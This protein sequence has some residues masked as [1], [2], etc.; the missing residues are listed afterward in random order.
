MKTVNNNESKTTRDLVFMIDTTGSM[1]SAIQALRT[2]VPEAV[3]FTMLTGVFDRI[4][5]LQYKDYD[6]PEVVSHSA[7]QPAT[8]DG[9]NTLI[10]YAQSLQP[11]GGAGQPEAVKTA[12][13]QLADLLQ[14]PT[15]VMHITDAPMH[16]KRLDREG[17]KE[18][19]VL[20]KYFNSTTL[21][22]HL[23][24]N[25]PVR[26]YALTMHEERQYYYFAARMDGSV[27]A[28]GSFHT[29]KL[30]QSM[31][32][33]ILS[34]V[35]EQL[36]G[37]R[38]NSLSGDII[39]T[40]S[41]DNILVQRYNQAAVLVGKNTDHTNRVFDVLDRIVDT[42]VMMLVHSPLFGSIWRAVCA[43]RRDNRRAT[44]I[45]RLSNKI[46]TLPAADADEL[47][48]WIQNSYDR[49]A[50]I[51]EELEEFI[52]EHGLHGTLS[53]H[54]DMTISPKDLINSFSTLGRD[55]RAR[56]IHVLTRLR[57]DN[58]DQKTLESGQLP[59]NLP[60]NKLFSLLLHTVAPGTKASQRIAALIAM[61]AVMSQSVLKEQAL[62]YLGKI[63]GTWLC[64]D[65]DEDGKPVIGEN[66]NGN[67]AYVC[68]NVSKHHPELFTPEELENV[69][70]INVLCRAYRLK[71]CEVTVE[72]EMRGGMDRRFRGYRTECK[73][74]HN[75]YP[76]TLINDVG[77]CGY[78]EFDMDVRY[79]PENDNFQQY[80]CTT[81]GYF[82]SANPNIHISGRRQC[83]WCK[84][85]QE[86]LDYIAQHGMSDCPPDHK[87]PGYQCT[88]CGLKYA[89]HIHHD[90]CA[91]CVN[92]EA[93]PEMRFNQS[94][95]LTH[96]LLNPEQLHGV[97]LTQG[98][99][100]GMVPPR[101]YD[102]FRQV[103]F[104]DPVPHVPS[105]L[106]WQEQEVCNQDAVWGTI[107]D[108]MDGK[109]V[110]LPSCSICCDT[111]RP[112]QLVL[113]CGRKSCGQRVCF[114]CGADWY[115]SEVGQLYNPRH[116][117]CPF[118][119]RLPAP[120]CCARWGVRTAGR[121]LDSSYYYAVCCTC[122]T[123][124]EHSAKSCSEGEP[125]VSGWECENCQEAKTDGTIEYMHCPSCSVPTSK[126]GG[127]NHI[128]CPCGQ[129]WCYV[130]GG[131]F[132]ANTIY[133]HMMSAHGGYFD[134]D[135]QDGD[136]YDSDDDEED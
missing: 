18:L 122:Q 118:C 70:H 24:T 109:S 59:L 2:T 106:V 68:T 8:Q 28:I 86:T 134:H 62:E 80:K 135:Y 49:S 73:Q 52:N 50:E 55:D 19:R 20:G 74:C 44:L 67:V 38:F 75:R 97:H 22:D 43:L 94:Q 71:N 27:Q 101:L 81:C 1:G 95:V 46:N 132:E 136:Y 32:N 34:W 124:Q 51:N 69:N 128:T 114:D 72:T 16:D 100:H 79:T 40:P 10:N 113:V 103:Q 117:S 115:R 93:V 129:H 63:R 91:A 45:N 15:Y 83:H 85:R 53:Y 33:L 5:I 102:A 82:Y 120:R 131:A 56:I 7:W 76:E 88:Q 4:M 57:V 26:Y 23:T 92:G 105:Q 21:I 121:K 6:V 116:A 35:T 96:R 37:Y 36:P 64:F 133:G 60:V 123:V 61:L 9:M 78:C 17:Q 99:D 126:T 87:T 125:D 31:V 89:S 54:Q 14:G 3:L 12:L 39:A 30:R 77:V 98:L 42:N 29:T 25:H 13:Y 107:L 130:C 111:F 84:E 119:D 90:R 58:T 48:T 104:T 110:Q 66:F 112:D 11:S 65:F 127:C 41:E 108:V 47:R